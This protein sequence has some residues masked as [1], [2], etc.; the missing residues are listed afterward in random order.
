MPLKRSKSYDNST[1]SNIT[2]NEINNRKNTNLH[3]IGYCEWLRCSSYNELA[4]SKLKNYIFPSERSQEN[5]S[6]NETKIKMQA[7]RRGGSDCDWY[8]KHDDYMS[9]KNKYQ[10]VV[11]I[12]LISPDL[13]NINRPIQLDEYPH[14]CCKCGGGNWC[15]RNIFKHSDDDRNRFCDENSRIDI[16]KNDLICNAS[17][18]FIIICNTDESKNGSDAFDVA[19]NQ[20]II[21]L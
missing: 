2:V 6:E 21:G 4:S 19:M 1:I 12:N 13:D 11:E 8:C 9:G 18:H 16:E 17:N 5:L 14:Q 20:K 10:N 15:G 7:Y 3:F